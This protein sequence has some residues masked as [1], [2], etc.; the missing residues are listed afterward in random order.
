MKNKFSLSNL[1][2]NSK[3]SFIKGGKIYSIIAASILLVGI[4][5]LCVMGFNLGIDFTGGTILQIK[6]G[7]T[8]S[9]DSVY[10]NY[11]NSIEEVLNKNNIKL[12]SSQRQGEN[13]E[14]SIVIRFQ[15]PDGIS[16]ED[17]NSTSG[18]IEKIKDD[19]IE[20]L[21][22]INSDVKVEITNSERISATASSSLLLNACLAILVAIIC[23][24]IYIAIRFEFFTGLCT[25]IALAHDVL[26]MCA[27][28][29]ICRVQINSTF[30]AAIITII[31]YSINNTIVVF[32]RVR[33]EWK[34][35]IGTNA[36]PFQDIID[37]S[38]K[39]TFTRS[40]YTSLTTLLAVVMLAILGTSSVM[41]FVVPIIF[42]LVAGT[43][44]SMF[45]AGPLLALIS[46]KH[47]IRF[48]MKK[49]TTVE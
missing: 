5:M 33:E 23:M 35:N 12:S 49:I 45:V 15:D 27:L 9:N 20:E 29:A 7:S 22:K 17:L 38:I 41:E 2:E 46:K 18:L 42:G 24:L 4:I 6:V 47:K 3:H 21:N 16:E 30:I 31:G 36:L 14:M 19:L 39:Q 11:K 1:V 28:C 8:L 44:S 13:G 25:L 37:K 43:L 40:I 32:D 48:R 10:N 34:I 26:M